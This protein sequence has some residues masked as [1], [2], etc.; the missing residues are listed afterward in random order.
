MCEVTSIDTTAG[1]TRWK[2]SANDN[3]PPGG[4]EK[5]AAV[6]TGVSDRLRSERA[7]DWSRRTPPPASAAAATP[8]KATPMIKPVFMEAMFEFRPCPQAVKLVARA[9]A[10][11]PRR[12]DSARLM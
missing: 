12:A 7:F 1:D 3:G 9:V 11:R 4:G 2:M 10:T 6:D 8:A 5:A